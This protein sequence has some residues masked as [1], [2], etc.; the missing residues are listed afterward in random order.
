[1]AA[2]P[3][4]TRFVSS[5]VFGGGV[6]PIDLFAEGYTPQ[7]TPEG[8]MRRYCASKY[9]QWLAEKFMT[10]LICHVDNFASCSD[11]TIT[12]D[13]KLMVAWYT[14]DIRDFD[15]TKQR[16]DNW[17]ADVN[18]ALFTR[19]K[20]AL[21]TLRD[22]IWF[23]QSAYEKLSRSSKSCTLWRGVDKRLTQVSKHYD[24]NKKV[25]WPSFTSASKD[26]S[27]MMDFANREGSL[28]KI[29]AVCYAD[30]SGLSMRPLEAESLLG[31]NTL[32][33]VQS[34]ITSE[35][36]AG[37]PGAE[38]IPPNVDLI[39][40][41]QIPTPPFGI[42][43]L[44]SAPPLPTKSAKRFIRYLTPCPQSHAECWAGNAPRTLHEKAT[45]KL[46]FLGYLPIHEGFTTSHV[47]LM[48]G[49]SAAAKL[50]LDT[51]YTA[52]S[53]TTSNG[54]TLL[55]AAAL[56]GQPVTVLQ[57][58]VQGGCV[59]TAEDAHGC[60]VMHYAA[61]GGSVDTLKYFLTNGG[62]VSGK[63]SDGYTVMMYAAQGGSVEAMKFVLANG[64]NMT[65][66]DNIG[67]TV[68]M[69]AAYGGSIEAMKLVLA[70]GGNMTDKRNDGGTVMML[71]AYGGSVEAMKFVLTNG[72]NMTGGS[73]EAMK[74][75]LA[76]GGNLTDKDSNGCTVMMSAAYGGSVEAM[77]F[78]L[79]N[80]GN[81]TDKDSNGCTVMMAAAYGG[82][83]E[84]MKLVLANGG[85][86]KGVL[87][88]CSSDE[89]KEF[90][91]S[92]GGD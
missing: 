48:C 12:R 41:K 35:Q 89:T 67:A 64:G 63:D 16:E 42:L 30:F 51:V 40:V 88:C 28:I 21:C 8:I 74:F 58:L 70:N 4:A 92:C 86:L 34:V 71:A 57:Q 91:R 53:I 25:C 55:H 79:A 81:L 45:V 77:K 82:S 19:N 52:G 47:A 15:P 7:G 49:S 1:M 32:V 85:S 3:H 36:L 38:S 18:A 72:G 73:V 44:H 20:E 75:V 6:I 22:G 62:N 9:L 87:R 5:D 10:A 56:G 39:I 11:P 69:S 37:F 14:S 90:C 26:Q 80:G 60:S 50:V 31:I 54:L 61:V 68:V 76:N 59:P 66:K 23:L 83:V 17:W 43:R 84:A 2:Q 65:D 33:E 78:V 46:F 24:R 27:V 13:E 29:E